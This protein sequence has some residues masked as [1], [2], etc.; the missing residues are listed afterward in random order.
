MPDDGCFQPRMGCSTATRRALMP[1]DGCFQPRMGCST[2]TRR[3]AEI[4]DAKRQRLDSGGGGIP[5]VRS[6]RE[7]FFSLCFLLVFLC[8]QA[9]LY[10]NVGAGVWGTGVVSWRGCQVHS[11]DDGRPCQDLRGTPEV[12]LS[13]PNGD[14]AISSSASLS[15]KVPEPRGACCVFSCR[16]S[17]RRSC[18]PSLRRMVPAASSVKESF[19]SFCFLL[20][21]PRRS[22]H[23]GCFRGG[24]DM[25]AV[26]AANVRVS[27][28]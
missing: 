7:I 1:D 26:L 3:E 5:A 18:P 8:S 10:G 2:A 27:A 4:K 25:P 9:I 20:V 19:C 22:R 17:L 28:V 23:A 6:E 16:P 24:L 15:R 13:A 21:L 14:S 11:G 12:C